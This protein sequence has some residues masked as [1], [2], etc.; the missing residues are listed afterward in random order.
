MAT[1]W[2]DLAVTDGDGENWGTLGELVDNAPANL[3]NAVIAAD[4]SIESWPQMYIAAPD[5]EADWDTPRGPVDWTGFAEALKAA[6]GA[7][8]D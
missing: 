8:E 2:K 3:D 6:R 5:E 7:V 4:G 1:N